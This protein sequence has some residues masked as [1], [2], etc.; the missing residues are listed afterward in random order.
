MRDARIYPLWFWL[1]RQ[2]ITRLTPAGEELIQVSPAVPLSLLLSA[3]GIRR[4]SS[5][6]TGGRN[7]IRNIFL[8]GGGGGECPSLVDLGNLDKVGCF[9]TLSRTDDSLSIRA[10]G[11]QTGVNKASG[12]R[13]QHQQA[14]L[15]HTRIH[16]NAHTVKHT[17]NSLLLP[18]G[19]VSAPL[20]LDSSRV[21][22][23]GVP[24]LCCSNSSFTSLPPL[25]LPASLFC[26]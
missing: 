26:Q 19:V 9:N 17:S 10:P 15:T 21:S 7:C 1:A 12:C 11:F 24:G 20:L 2:E 4:A 13:D 3:H 6:Y 8:L 14:P 5:N 23:C 22:P 16:T 25:P 18:L